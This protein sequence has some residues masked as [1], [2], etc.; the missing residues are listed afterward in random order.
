M[1]TSSN[2]ASTAHHPDFAPGRAL[3]LHLVR[4]GAT[5][6]VVAVT[7]APELRSHLGSLGFVE[8]AAVKV[9][10]AA[11]GNLIVDVKGARLALGRSMARNVMT[12]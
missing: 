2:D 9:I 1:T 3:P 12:E 11:D 10:S 4:L 6:R 8:S 5:V 7:G